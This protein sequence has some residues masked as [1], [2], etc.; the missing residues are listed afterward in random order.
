MSSFAIALLVLE[1]D[2]GQIEKIKFCFGQLYP[3]SIIHAAKDGQDFI[4]VLRRLQGRRKIDLILLDINVPKINGI[5]ILR[6]LDLKRSGNPSL[7][8]S[9]NPD[10][11]SIPTVMFTNGASNEDVVRC[12]SL[13]A[14]GVEYKPGFD[15]FGE[16]IAHIVETYVRDR[17]PEDATNDTISGIDIA[18]EKQKMSGAPSLKTVDQ[19]LEDW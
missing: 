5:E 13:G 6:R 12:K 19:L 7:N 10:G 17:P 18:E 11:C 8:I 15:K 1:D 9:A 14:K 4:D 2:D 16:A 3:N